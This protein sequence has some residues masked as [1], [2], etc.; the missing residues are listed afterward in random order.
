MKKAIDQLRPRDQYQRV[1]AQRHADGREFFRQFGQSFQEVDC[2]ACGSAQ[3]QTVFEK[4]GFSHRLCQ[5]C[6]TLYC[7]PRPGEDLLSRF[8]T[9]FDSPKMWTK[10][11]LQANRERKALQHRPRVE[12][13][14]AH[15][16][17]LGIEPGGVACDVGAGSGAF[18]LALQEC[19]LFAKVLALD[20]S[21]DCVTACAGVGLEAT[22]G[23]VAVLEDASVNIICTNDLV[24]HLF[25][26]AAFLSQCR[27]KLAPGGFISIATPNGQGFDFKIL[28]PDTV[29]ITPPE[30]LTY[31]NP[32]SITKLL[33]RTG[34]SVVS[35]ETPGR[36]D[37]DMVLQA[38][39]QGFPLAEKN[40]Y[41]DFVLSQGEEVQAALQ[42]F[43]AANLLS[44]HM[45]VLARRTA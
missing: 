40:S 25:D 14:A 24:E 6:A 29:N 23:P 8:Y 1:L 34:F 42:A 33:E 27:H 10:L 4:L 17:R 19:G 2:P 3:Q 5:D 43:L 32:G 45:L 16:R 36:L 18:A 35:L 38:R 21:P 37:V 20:I 22:C 26:P 11:L 7:S 12:I 9:E 41:L 44:S 31:F 28:G 30:H 39:S 13:I 15:L